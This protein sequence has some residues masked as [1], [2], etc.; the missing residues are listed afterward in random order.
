MPRFKHD[1]HQ[2]SPQDFEFGIGKLAKR[3][4]EWP[5]EPK[6]FDPGRNQND[7]QVC[8]GMERCSRQDGF[9]KKSFGCLETSG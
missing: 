7:S 8:H 5:W 3:N 1:R 6:E 4:L 9:T 2:K